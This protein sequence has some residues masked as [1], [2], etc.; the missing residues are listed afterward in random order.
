MLVCNKQNKMTYTHVRSTAASLVP[1][2]TDNVINE[3]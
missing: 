1:G 3:I 2:M